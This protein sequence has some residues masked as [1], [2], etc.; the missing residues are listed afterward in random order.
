MARV[1]QA[2]GENFKNKL[3]EENFLKPQAEA[4]ELSYEYA[5]WLKGVPEVEMVRSLTDNLWTCWKEIR[6]ENNSYYYQIKRNQGKEGA[7]FSPGFNWEGEIKNVYHKTVIKREKNKLPF[8]RERA[9]YNGFCLVEKEILNTPDDPQN[10]SSYP[11]VLIISPPPEVPYG[12][13]GARS[14][15]Y[16]GQK[17]PVAASNRWELQIV[18]WEN[19]LSFV[20]HQLVFEALG[21]P[22]PLNVN[23]MLE[24]PIIMPQSREFQEPVDFLKIVSRVLEKTRGKT[25][26]L[27]REIDFRQIQRLQRGELKEQA[28]KEEMRRLAFQILDLFKKDPTAGQLEKAWTAILCAWEEKGMGLKEYFALREIMEVYRY[29]QRPEFPTA[30]PGGIGGR[31]SLVSIWEPDS[32]LRNNKPKEQEGFTC[33]KCHEKFPPTVRVGDRCPACG[34]TKEQYEKDHGVKAC[35]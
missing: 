33:P 21:K 1:E 10:P 23:A 6:R 3:R 31:E 8:E 11:L 32:F 15:Y 14:V 26:V 4:Y 29:R 28:E 34:Y 22:V 25:T 30:C 24:N 35:A 18:R 17:Q 7:L 27:G 19:D 16:L 9:E 13:Y 12:N 5:R 2:Y 20:E